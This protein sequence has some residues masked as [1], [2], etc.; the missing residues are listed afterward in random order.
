M[1]IGKI[2]DPNLT[3]W[4]ACPESSQSG[5]YEIVTFSH[6]RSK[7]MSENMIECTFRL[8]RPAK[9]Q[10]SLRICTGWSESL[11]S[12]YYIDKDPRSLLADSEDSGHTAQM[13]GAHVQR[14]ILSRCVATNV[15][16]WYKLVLP[17][18]FHVKRLHKWRVW[19]PQMSRG[20]AFPTKLHLRLAKIQ[21]SM[22]IRAVWS[23]SS[24]CTLWVSK[25]PKRL[26]TENEDSD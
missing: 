22:C 4:A 3:D 2:E 19:K 7:Y 24:Q 8:V 16:V 6:G 14:Y 20:T 10:F 26:Q 15:V 12:T 9:T 23:E 18:T 25:Y 5:Y 1:W 13:L 17:C 11:L 21:I